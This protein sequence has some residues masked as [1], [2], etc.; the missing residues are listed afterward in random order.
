MPKGN[1]GV[2]RVAVRKSSLP[3]YYARVKRLK[4]YGAEANAIFEA[5]ST[6]DLC[7][8]SRKLTID[9]NHSTGA[10]R[11]VLCYK[12][13]VGLGLFNEDK[14]LLLKAIAYVSQ[15]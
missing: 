4:R 11:G 1:P 5:A 12:C 2:K 7:G 10:F 8:Q 14:E 13:N 6:C 3:G 9:H 15:E